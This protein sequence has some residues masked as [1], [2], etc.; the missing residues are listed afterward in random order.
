[1]ESARIYPKNPQ[2]DYLLRPTYDLMDKIRLLLYFVKAG[3]GGGRE[4]R[5]DSFSK[6]SLQLQAQ[7]KNRVAHEKR[8]VH[9]F[10]QKINLRPPA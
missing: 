8:C 1:M 4:G 2:G 10:Q 5:A 6:I 7:I 9:I 3:E